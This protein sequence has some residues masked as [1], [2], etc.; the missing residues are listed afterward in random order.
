MFHHPLIITPFV[1]LVIVAALMFVGLAFAY[2]GMRNVCDPQSPDDWRAKF[3]GPLGVGMLVLCGA[4]VLSI[5]WK[6]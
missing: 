4:V 5:A 3:V 1:A 2:I 6:V